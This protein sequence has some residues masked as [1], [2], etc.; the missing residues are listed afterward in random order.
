MLFTAMYYKQSSQVDLLAEIETPLV[1]GGR[2]ADMLLRKLWKSEAAI[3]MCFLLF[4]VR[5]STAAS[6]SSKFKGSKK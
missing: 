1:S 5:V 2:G 6:V 4:K 3:K